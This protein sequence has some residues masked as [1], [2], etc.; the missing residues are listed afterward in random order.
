MN[1]PEIVRRCFE[2]DRVL[3]S[4]HA[5]RE[6]RAEEFGAIS[7]EEVN[8]AICAGE[9]IETYPEDSPYPSALIFGR[10]K[11]VRPLHI[12]CAYDR[13]DDRSVIVTVYQPDPD[14]WEDFRR[15][16]K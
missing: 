6:M 5:R 9:V 11:A 12:V 3:Y 15:R 1:W 13:L 4:R 10:T 16:K 2:R 7:D 14:Q 8:E